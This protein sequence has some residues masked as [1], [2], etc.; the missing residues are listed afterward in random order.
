MP[1]RHLKLSSIKELNET[2]STP[3]VFDLTTDKDTR[4]VHVLSQYTKGAMAG[5]R[6]SWS[7]IVK[8]LDVSS[9]YLTHF[10]VNIEPNH[11]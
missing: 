8:R 6:D 2:K 10:S 4:L 3:T 7:K 5:Y 11:N 9:P 1:P